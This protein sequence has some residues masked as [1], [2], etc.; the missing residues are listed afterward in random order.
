M[1]LWVRV[2]GLA[3]AGVVLGG[4]V[5]GL[6]YASL[7]TANYAVA[8]TASSI[9]VE[10]NRRVESDTI[11]SYF[12][13]GPGEKLDALKVDE[14]VKALF[15]TGLFADVRPSFQVGR[16]V[17]MVVENSVISRVQF[18]GNKRVK[19]EQLKGE[20]QSKPRGA[21]SRPLVQAD[22][23]R[24]VEIYR[25]NGRYDVRVEPKIIDRSNNRV[26]LVFEINEGGKT[27]V[28]DIDFVG[29][30][31]YSAWRL[32]DVIKTGST[33]ILS[34]LK[35]N[36]LYDPD[37]I[38]SDRELLRRWYL[39]NGYADVRIVSAVAEFDPKRNG[40]ILTFTIEEGDRYT[41]GKIDVQ[42]GMRDVS[43]AELRS[44]LRF[45]SGQTYNAEAIEKS[46]EEMTIEV[47]K[48]GYAFASV[49]P[50]GDRNYATHQVDIVFSVEEGARAY[51]ERI[52]VRGNTRTRDYVIRREFD[53][54]EGD[55]YNRVLVDRAERRLK[56]LNYFKTVKITTEPGSASDR[57]ILNVDVE[58]QST[59]EFS[60]AGGYSTSDGIV[61]E[62]SVGERNLLGRGQTARAS[63]SYGQYS[64]GVEF[65]FG[66]PYFLDYRLAFGIDLFAKQTDAS[67]SY[68]YR[69]QNIGAGFRFGIPLREDL[70]IQLRYSAY[71]QRIDL[72]QTL[73]NCNNIS[74]NFGLD[75]NN[76][77]TYP[78]SGAY[79]MTPATTPPVGYTGLASCYADGE[80]S[81][82][83]KQLVDAGPAIVSLVGYSLIYN[84]LDANKNP[85]R[86]MLA[87]LRQDFAGVG[88]DVNF[89]RTTGDAR[90]YYQL[91]ADITTVLHVQGGYVTSWGDKDLRML[92]HFQMGPNLV[93]GF[94]TA[95]IGPR[96]VTYGTSN[97]ALGGTT[98]WGA[99]LEAQW[100]IFG[101]PKDFGLRL[102]VFADA[103][104]VW[105]YTGPRN[106]PSTGTSIT[107][108]DP[109]TGKDT[110]SM[111]VRTSVGAGLIWD[112][113]FGPIRIDYA[114]PL[115]KDPNDRVQQLRFSGGTKF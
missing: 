81:A 55:A 104:S 47:S 83:V 107:T 40:F 85:T 63:V 54:A 97:D 86:G 2:R 79:G 25:R 103:G 16:L 69:Q 52:N 73:T 72:D 22:V 108:V 9:V 7:V 23:Q 98:Y 76:P 18:E 33:N 24:I 110:D 75:P 44:K 51:I 3:I 112:S 106:F 74:P 34:F 17:D 12:R 39:K 26:D 61:G 101:V 49:R 4:A 13:L 113:P 64:R 41:F 35:N 15:A 88:G 66:E 60:V 43:P 114:F 56:N 38:E 65:S 91:I 14:G 100:P 21:L 89:V 30:R 78:T 20:V 36:D 71:Q 53:I 27:T 94:A 29:N 96:D 31:A 45:S 58:E 99:S 42:S 32:K 6:G 111:L 10:G 115:T 102:A 80:A 11:R 59:G 87:E 8:Q 57:V 46:Q 48:R 90:W 67:S 1:R 68:V 109:F 62:V 93:R 37:R 70:A 84:T 77:A 19:D 92:D 5:L 95:G 28:K 82:A 50:R 105:N